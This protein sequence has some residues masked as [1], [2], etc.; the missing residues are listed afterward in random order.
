[1]RP[2]ASAAKPSGRMAAPAFE[3][4]KYVDISAGQYDY[5]ASAGW[6]TG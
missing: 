6:P 3:G 1:M 5:A 4:R 2:A